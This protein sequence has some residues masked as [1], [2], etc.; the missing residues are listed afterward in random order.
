MTPFLNATMRRLL[1]LVIVSVLLVSCMRNHSACTVDIANMDTTVRPQDDF[2]QYACGRWIASHP[3]PEDKSEYDVSTYVACNVDSQ[4]HDI[5]LDVVNS[6]YEPGSI[7]EKIAT[8]FKSGMDTLA[9]EAEGIKP[10]QFFFDA[11]R[12][13]ADLQNGITLLQKHYLIS[14][15]AIQYGP[16]LSNS[17]VMAFVISEDG[18]AL[19]DAE[20]YLDDDEYYEEVRAKY[21]EFQMKLFML[22]GQDSSTAL[23]SAEVA[24]NIEYKLAQ[25]SLDK[26]QSKNRT[27]VVHNCNLDDL[28]EQLPAFDWHK[29]FKQLE[30]P[31]PDTIVISAG[32]LYLRELDTLI[33]QTSIDDWKIYLK[34]QVVRGMATTLDS[35]FVNEDFYFKKR[36]LYGQEKK[37]PRW[38]LVLDEVKYDFDDAIGKMYVDKYFPPEAKRRVQEMTAKLK[39]AMAKRISDVSWMCD[40]TKA[41]ALHKLAKTRLKV[42]C[43]ETFVDYSDYVMCNSYATN[44]ITCMSQYFKYEMS[45]INREID[46]ESV[47]YEI[48][49]YNVNMYTVYNQNEI[50]IPAAI[51][52]PPFFYA[53]GDDAVNYGAVGA[54]IAHELTHGFDTQGR[55][56]D[57]DGN[58]NDWWTD[59]DK[60]EFDKEA[61]KLI[62]RFNSF[63]VIDSMHADG[64]FTLCENVADLGGLVVAYEAFSKTEQWKDQTKL[65]DGLTPDQ[66]FF[67]AYAQTWAGSYRDEAIRQLTK[68]NQHSLFRYR[69]EGP[70]P[71]IGAFEK[72]F[73]IKP[74]DKYYVPDSLKINIW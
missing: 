7:N 16:Y 35:A 27:H 71:N 2:Y 48:L 60:E 15:F 6:K 47:W 59:K 36:F 43:P 8:F 64:E 9:I 54:A 58:L 74:G 24:Y 67:I 65:I 4:I 29:F 26:E 17:S 40:S 44:V 31:I 70:L 34:Y 55:M 46:T 32:N 11:M 37:A 50:V 42:G 1:P 20:F 45:F 56:Y 38:S 10:L 49:P 41:K 72:A 12:S 51:L 73:D 63:I 61:Q 30:I 21:K 19:D 5:I 14:P 22:L 68:T 3:M 25:M 52:Q 13:V 39:E 66:R 33:R 53:D 69:T 18:I 23:Q 62:D 57:S 28:A